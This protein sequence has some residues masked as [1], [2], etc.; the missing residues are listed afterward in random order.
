M[1]P[2][3]LEIPQSDQ[4]INELPKIVS[5][6]GFEIKQT[7]KRWVL[8]FP[9]VGLSI[10]GLVL[11]LR[12]WNE[13]TQTRS[14]VKMRPE[15]GVPAEPAQGWVS[16]TNADYGFSLYH[17]D[18][19][20]VEVGSE[21]DPS[22]PP[23]AVM[24][25][26]E[27][28][29]VGVTIVSLDNGS[30]GSTGF[31]STPR[32]GGFQFV[33]DALAASGTP[34]I[35][36]LP[37][38]PAVTASATGK[39]DVNLEVNA[40]NT[41]EMRISENSN[42]SGAGWEPYSALKPWTFV[43]ADGQKMV[44]AQFKNNVGHITETSASFIL[45][46]LPPFG[47]IAFSQGV[48]GPSTS[49]IILYFGAEDNASG[50]TDMR[51]STDPNF[52]DVPWEV[53]TTSRE[54][55]TYATWEEGRGQET[56]YVQYRDLVGNISGVYSDTYLVDRTPPDVYVE[57]SRG[58]TLIR[59]T[60]TVLAW[61]ELADIADMRVTNDPLMMEGVVTLPYTETIEWTFDDHRVVWVQV[62]DS[63]GNWGEPYPA[64][65]SLPSDPSRPTSTPTPMDSTTPTPSETGTP[66]TTGAAPTSG[67]SSGTQGA[68]SAEIPPT[69]ET[70][71]TPD[72]D[73]FRGAQLTEWAAKAFW[74]TSIKKK[75]SMKEVNKLKVV[76]AIYDQP[77]TETVGKR[78]IVT[79]FSFGDRSYMLIVEVG[80]DT[81][82]E[83]VVSFP[84]RLPIY[85]KIV[86][87][88]TSL[89][90]GPRNPLPILPR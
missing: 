57:V 3:E 9:V 40:P 48:V 22:L 11:G 88:F 18:G 34:R 15:P 72:V 77:S 85:E 67:E 16:Y 65:A 80:I 75:L 21:F 52:G 19:W 86:E 45:D 2:T 36:I 10:L 90:E 61:D 79:T 20:E 39:P 33:S 1:L 14:S 83:E 43:G 38:W 6:F 7:Y 84:E 54:W 62:E 89:P 27:S 5:L 69:A 44:Y 31:R 64:F 82:T 29:S 24:L 50:V 74:P 28:G 51:V 12:Y 8:L 81:A 58:E 53:Y 35:S 37:E 55:F 47:G 49:T 56:A 41:V 63:V 70:F 30:N 76:R 26:D 60:V 71:Q 73:F 78:F 66:P 59:R 42:F 17:P 68:P 46:T 87:S 32:R 25:Q 23:S 4:E 13:Q